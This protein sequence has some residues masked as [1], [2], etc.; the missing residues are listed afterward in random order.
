MVVENGVVERLSERDVLVEDQCEDREIGEDGVEPHDKV[1]V[2]NIDG[3]VVEDYHEQGL[4]G[5]DQ[6]TAVHHKV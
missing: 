6:K 5:G 2:V 3:D 4:D 1:P